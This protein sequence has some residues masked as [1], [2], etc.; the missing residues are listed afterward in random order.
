[1]AGLPAGRQERCAI[2]AESGRDFAA[3]AA[4]TRLLSARKVRERI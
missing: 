2:V 4:A 1:M 3:A